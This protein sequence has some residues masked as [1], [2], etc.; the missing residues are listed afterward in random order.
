MYL[1]SWAEE[2]LQMKISKVGKKWLNM[3]TQQSRNLASG[4]PTRILIVPQE[5]QSQKKVLEK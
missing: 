4:Q 1:L 5:N 2:K 3:K